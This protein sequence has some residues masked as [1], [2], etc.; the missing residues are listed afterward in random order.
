MSAI[1]TTRRLTSR[2]A[3]YA[4]VV[5]AMVGLLIEN[6]PVDATPSR[7]SS[8]WLV[9]RD[10]WSVRRDVDATR[11]ERATT[12]S[13]AHSAK[14]FTASERLAGVDRIQTA[15]TVSKLL[16]ADG[17]NSVVVFGSAFSFAD[18]LAG[19]GAGV[20]FGSAALLTEPNS[21]NPDSLEEANRATANRMTEAKKAVLLG[22]TAA[23]SET[24]EAQLRAAGF[25]TTRVAGENRF[26]TAVAISDRFMGDARY[27]ILVDGRNPIEAMIGGS[28]AAVSTRRDMPPGE[29]ALYL[30]DG[31]QLPPETLYAI[32]SHNF[33]KVFTVG[34]APARAYPQGEHILGAD[35][36]ELSVNVARTFP[37]YEK[38]QLTFA[39]SRE[40]SW[41]D[42]LNAGIL[43]SYSHQGNLIIV[44]R[45]DTSG[46]VDS[47][48]EDVHVNIREAFICGGTAAISSMTEE[49]INT[50]L[51]ADKQ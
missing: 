16:T 37:E 45:D 5:S 31:D 38:G 8:G 17:D 29:A 13:M 23:L 28:A 6:A 49:K 26:S 48:L 51:S 19:T 14:A 47:F 25:E 3:R 36:S 42:G 20:Q 15:I 9:Q 2:A 41:P 34:E 21:L 44:G 10:E 35:P 11:D 27:L 30:T 40:R 18:I 24:V 12:D 4:C 46:V 33:A 7:T 43:A 50:A 39:S 1:P 22:G 32:N